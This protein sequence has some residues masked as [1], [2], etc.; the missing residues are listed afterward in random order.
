[1]AGKIKKEHEKREKAIPEIK[2]KAVKGI[3]EKIQKNNTILV[4]STRGLPASQFQ[5]IKKSFRGTSE[6]VV[7]KRS[8]VLRAMEQV[9]KPG[10][11]E[12]ESYIGENIALFISNVDAFEL[13]GKLIDNQSPTKA[14]VGDIVP[15][16]IHVEPGPTD[17]MP[18]PAISELGAVGL[19]VGV[20]GGKI[21][22]KQAATLVKKGE[23]VNDKV[24]AVL[25]KLNITPMKVGF[26]P[27]AAYD[28]ASGKI[29]R[30]IKIDKKEALESLR[31][32]IGRAL[33]FA[34]NVKYPT[35]ET[36]KYFIMKARWEELA[37]EK[38]TDA[39]NSG[40]EATQ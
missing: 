30:D 26:I 33:G 15:E 14:R 4:A 29:Y 31:D 24:A 6:V 28:G 10:L 35:P 18:G 2:I 5:K 21:A 7:A 40:K 1:M 39:Q 25:G 17:L 32:S 13:A 16:D 34:V 36:V 38:K 19:K 12:L 11:N 23:A 9:K 27:V 8:L 22:I 37:L 3:V 20:E